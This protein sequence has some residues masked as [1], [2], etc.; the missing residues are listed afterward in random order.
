VLRLDR[1][2]WSVGSGGQKGSQKLAG[3]TTSVWSRNYTPPR[4]GA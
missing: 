2:G 3:G 4:K 1:F